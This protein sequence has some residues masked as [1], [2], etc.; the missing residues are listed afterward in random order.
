MRIYPYPKSLEREQGGFTLEDMRMG[1]HWLRADVKC[2][3][4]GKEMSLAMA[5]STDNGVCV[6]CGGKAS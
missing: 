1:N 5:G 6:R 2:V 4:C 3:D